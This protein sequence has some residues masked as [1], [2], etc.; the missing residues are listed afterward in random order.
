MSRLTERHL[1]MMPL[2]PRR[3]L[4]EPTATTERPPLAL[5]ALAFRPFFLAAG[6]LAT[7]LVPL[8][9][10][11]FFGKL[12]LPSRLYPASWHGHEMV[13]GFAVAVIAGFLLT[14]ARNW[15]STPTVSGA[16]LGAL[17]ALFLLGRVF[18]L[19]GASLPEALVV[20]VDLAFLPAVAIALAMPIVRAKNWRNLA[21]VPL[22]LVLAAANTL[23]Y[24]SP[25]RASA[26]LRF[27]LGVILVIITVMGGRVI[28]A[29]TANALR[30]EVRK[31][32]RLDAAAIAAVALSA[33]LEL[34]P[35]DP[36]VLGVAAIVAGVLNLA[37]LSRWHPLATR[38][39]SILWVLHL[40][41]GWLALGLVLKGVTAFVPTWI[42]TASLH[43]LAVGSIATLILGMMTRV[44]LGHT[45]RMLAVTTSIALGYVSLGVAALLRAIG[46]LVVPSAY[47]FLLIASGVAWTIA[48]AIFL[49]GYFPMLIAP[50]IDGKP[51]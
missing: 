2:A 37:R 47:R 7:L 16:K 10:F 31:T 39:H 24:L 27:A 15:T 45:G 30:L 48:F 20:A 49:I 13:F 19:F 22:L 43:A 50:R 3:S 32:P 33:I 42:P 36:R 34:A 18:V 40:G 28:P 17:V 5:L 12:T 51:G 23:F 38:A 44:S 25:L 26:A 6:V 29:F 35:V 4:I 14:A 8:W 1:N 9:L 21:F 41:Y 46:P 11:A